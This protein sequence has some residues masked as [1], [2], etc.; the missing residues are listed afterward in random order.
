M[1]NIIDFSEGLIMNIVNRD[2]ILT[3]R[4]SGP[5]K[6]ENAQMSY[7]VTLGILPDVTGT[8]NDGLRVDGVRKDGPA[9]RGGIKK[10]D[11]IVQMA[12]KPVK[13]IYEYMH[14]L[15]QLEPGQTVVVDLLRN[16]KKVVLLIQL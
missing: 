14:R 1:K 15:N 16:G 2:S 13:N 9:E 7:K 5:K 10:G 4:E 3:Y 8:S 12:G 6:D 11:V